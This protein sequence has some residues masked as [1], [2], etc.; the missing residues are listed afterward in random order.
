M[1]AYY[2]ILG[3]SPDASL[4][5]IK[6]AYRKKAIKLHPDKNPSPDAQEQFMKLDAAYDYLVAVKKGKPINDTA[7]FVEILNN[8][9]QQ[10]KQKEKEEKNK[11]RRGYHAAWYMNEKNKIY[12]NHTGLTT[13]IGFFLVVIL[14][15]VED[16]VLTSLYGK[17]Y[18]FKNK[19]MIGAGVGI[20]I[21]TL[22]N[23]VMTFERNKQ[24][25][26]ARNEY[27]RRLKKEGLM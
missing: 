2:D 8:L 10:E 23:R 5:E 25:K 16:V 26:N 11:K 19:L 13:L 12:S 24:L 15:V 1:Q 4:S 14:I 9:F 3:V 21:I 18:P 27:F 20:I 7:D 22:V 17:F 6:K